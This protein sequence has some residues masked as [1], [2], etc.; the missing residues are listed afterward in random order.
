MN[1]KITIP[2]LGDIILSQYVAG[3]V[4]AVLFK[5]WVKH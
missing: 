1:K 3:T 4:S 2:I 5:R